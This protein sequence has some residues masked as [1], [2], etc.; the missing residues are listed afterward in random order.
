MSSRGETVFG[1]TWGSAGKHHC[2]QSVC[3]YT[4]TLLQG[5]SHQLACNIKPVCTNHYP[6]HPPLKVKGLYHKVSVG[7][8]RRK[9]VIL[10]RLYYVITRRN[11]FVSTWG[12]RGSALANKD[13]FQRIAT[14]RQGQSRLAMT[15]RII[16]QHCHFHQ[17]IY[18][19]LCNKVL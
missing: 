12:S 10:T 8:E 6:D 15:I 17:T 14:L 11:C 4:I 5:M 18:C 16:H 13:A 19:P 7:G 9:N 2:K 1:S 3:A